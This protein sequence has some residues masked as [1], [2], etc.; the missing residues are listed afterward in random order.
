MSRPFHSSAAFIEGLSSQTDSFAVPPPAV[1]V[2]PPA[3]TRFGYLFTQKSGDRLE[4]TVHTTANLAALGDSM[5]DSKVLAAGDSQIPSVYTYFG[6]FIA[7]DLTFDPVTKD[8]PL[9]PEI[10]PLETEIVNS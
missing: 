6:Q 1:I 8:R 10:E 9:N 3:K 5:R 4:E 7:H 2:P